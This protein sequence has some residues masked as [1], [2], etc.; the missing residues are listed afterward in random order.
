MDFRDG[1]FDA[2]SR[3]ILDW[4]LIRLLKKKKRCFT[5]SVPKKK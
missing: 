5:V 3:K 2:L 1:K 4:G